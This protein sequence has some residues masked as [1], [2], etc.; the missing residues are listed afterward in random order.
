M[1]MCIFSKTVVSHSG[2]NK[3]KGRAKTLA[4]GMLRIET[5]NKSSYYRH[6]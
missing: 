2:G 1:N 3:R 6:F 5:A 4:F